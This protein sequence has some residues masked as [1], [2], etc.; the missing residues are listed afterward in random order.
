MNWTLPALFGAA[1]LAYFVKGAT[2]FGPAMVMISISSLIIGPQP[3]I[4]LSTLLDIIGGIL[5][6]RMDR[7]PG[8]HGF[9]IPMSVM[10]VIGTVIGGY[11]LT[12]IPMDHFT[13]SLSVVIVILGLWFMFG[14]QQKHA[15]NFMTEL[16]QTCNNIDLAVTF[17]SGL[18][19]GLFGI[20]GPPIV[21]H[22]SRKLAKV[23]FRQAL[24]AIF[25]VAAATRVTTYTVTGIITWQTLE[26]GFITLP[27][28]LIGL[29]LGNHLFFKLSE[30]WFRRFVGLVLFLAGLRLFFR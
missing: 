29:Y 18:C 23:A 27:G 7:S 22:L 28:L 3:A 12:I 10:M 6:F 4:A 2:G 24:I 1:T 8:A 13:L 19:G 16:P 15:H 20:S 21:Y 17:I 14:N 25:L 11:F 30:V 9:W 5:L 26:Y